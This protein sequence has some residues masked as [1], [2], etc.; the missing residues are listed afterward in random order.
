MSLRQSAI[1]VR[2]LEGIG[3]QPRTLLRF[4]RQKGGEQ[5]SGL[6]PQMNVLD[7]ITR[8]DSCFGG[9]FVIAITRA[10]DKVLCVPGS[11]MPVEGG[12][13]FAREFPADIH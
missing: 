8:E 13:G 11:S 12:H 6:S 5:R 1:A 7:A 4:C 2:R 10:R 9:D 3:G